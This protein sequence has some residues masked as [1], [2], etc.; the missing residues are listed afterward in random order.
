MVSVVSYAL[1]FG[2][3]CEGPSEVAE[4]SIAHNEARAQ[5]LSYG[6]LSS[7]YLHDRNARAGE[8]APILRPPRQRELREA[9]RL[10]TE[11]AAPIRA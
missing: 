4:L 6:Q 3:A 9:H 1:E 2:R 11:I 8:P 10:F 7:W 5:L